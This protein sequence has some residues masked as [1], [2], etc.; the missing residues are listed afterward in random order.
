[1]DGFLDVTELHALC[2]GEAHFGDHLAG[3]LADDGRGDDL[4]GS[5]L[6]VNPTEAPVLAFGLSAVVVVD[7]EFVDVDVRG[8][9]REF[10]IRWAGVGD[11]RI[12]VSHPAHDSVLRVHAIR[13]WHQGV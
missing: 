5:L 4:V 3:V 8:V 10:G 7:G 13:P 9:F 2:D 6:A 11:F 1:M 12:S